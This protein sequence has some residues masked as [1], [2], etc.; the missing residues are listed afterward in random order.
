M[1]RGERPEH[2]APPDI[3]YNEDEARKYATNSRMIAIQEKL[4]ERA[5]E[6]L[7]LTPDG[8][9]RLLLDI[10]CGSG[11]SGESLTSAGHNWVGLDIS[12]AMLG[13]AIQREAEGDLLLSDMGQGLPLRQGVFDGAISKSAV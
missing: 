9:P 13:V 6:L 7:A 1:G 12:A 5:L 4:T 11:L 8:A 2:A 3:F 10:G